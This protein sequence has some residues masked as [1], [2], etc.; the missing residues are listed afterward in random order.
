MAKRQ[1]LLTTIQENFKFLCIEVI[2]QVENTKYELKFHDEKVI[3][4]IAERD[5]YI[6]NLKT[7]IENKCFQ[8]HQEPS[9]DKALVNL[10]RALNVCTSNLEK[11]ADYSVNIVRQSTYLPDP[12]FIHQFDPDPLFDGILGALELVDGA[13]ADRDVSRGLRICRT[14]FENDRLYLAVFQRIMQKLKSGEQPEQLVTSLF[15]FQYLERMADAVLNIGE[16]VIFAAVGEKIKVSQ[17]EAIEETLEGSHLELDF[18]DANYK[19]IWETRS[20]C[21]IGTIDDK[22]RSPG[23]TD[24]VFKEGKTQKVLE[25]KKGIEK[26]EQLMP[27]LPPKVFGHQDL[28]DHS[29]IL[30]EFLKGETFQ[31]ITVNGSVRDKRKACKLLFTTLLDAWGRSRSEKRVSAGYINQLRKRMKDVY[32]VHPEFATGH[33]VIGGI[34]QDSFAELV[35]KAEKIDDKVDAPFSVMIHGDFNT[36]NVLINLDAEKVHFIDLHRARMFDYLQ[37]VSVFIVSNLRFPVQTPAVRESLS[38][39]SME[40]FGFAREFARKNEDKTFELRLALGLIRSFATSTRFELKEQFAKNLF[41]RAIYL[42]E[43]VVALK[44]SEYENF[45]IDEDILRF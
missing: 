21:R 36:D 3:E 35:E 31:R 44:E 15:I 32:K 26:W 19:G 27:G 25:E 43:K 40:M 10:I 38:A 16:A 29:A 39:A 14:E 5:D 4:R 23:T 45:R 8:I 30:V 1:A 41:H 37:D 12:T 7:L 28:G 6:D 17:Y 33:Q 24:A 2:E 11:I 20:G 42:L 22:T 34:Q 18:S 13:L 9:V